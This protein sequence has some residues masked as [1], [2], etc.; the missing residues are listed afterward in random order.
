M[1]LWRI[2][3]YATLNGQGGL[4]ASARWRSAGRPIVYLS[5]SPAAALLEKLVHLELSPTRLPKAYQLLK[6]EAPDDVAVRVVTAA[7][8]PTNWIAD[9]ITT[10]TLGDEWL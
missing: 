6:A 9:E 8:L 1:F 2:S 10:Q 5:D 3:N 4:T 7:D